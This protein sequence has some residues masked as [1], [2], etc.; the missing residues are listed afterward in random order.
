MGLDLD[1][2][3]DR[4][5]GDAILALTED[6]R[7]DQVI[8]IGSRRK[9]K[10]G[11]VVPHYFAAATAGEFRSWLPELWR[12]ELQVAQASYWI[13]QPMHS[14]VRRELPTASN[15]YKSAWY[16]AT[17][18]RVDG[19]NCL[20]IDLDVGRDGLPTAGDAI[21]IMANAVLEGLIPAPSY[22][23]LSGRGAYAIWRLRLADGGLPPNNELN[24][25]RW[26]AILYRLILITKALELS[27]DEIAKNPARWL[28]LPGTVDTQIDSGRET[29]SGNRVMYLPFLL[30]SPDAKPAVYTF[31]ELESE[32][33]MA[34]PPTLPASVAP[35]ARRVSAPLELRARPDPDGRNGSYVHSARVNEIVALSNSRG[36]MSEPHRHMSLFY[37]YGSLRAQYGC[38]YPGEGIAEQWARARTYELNAS[39][40]PPLAPA[41]V[42]TAIKRR[43]AGAKARWKAS[44]VAA[45]LGVAPSEAEALQLH[46]IAPKV[47]RDD[48]EQRARDGVLDRK[49]AREEKAQAIRRLLLDHS[50]WSDLTVAQFYG[51]IDRQLVAYYRKGLIEEGLLRKPRPPR[52]TQQKLL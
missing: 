19:F 1:Q 24:R 27:P 3:D 18:D 36:G 5:N 8:A 45:A 34:S 38:L 7:D 46:S 44:T 14:S 6:F 4:A 9:T 21:K 23:A 22:M 13:M 16:P 15:E 52:P 2:L 30:D 29:K 17:N 40:N 31:D 47:V 51:G 32:L 48:R 33:G 35:V 41:E 50:G 42:E 12:Y 39:F 20:P 37:F 49:A 11:S 10:A 43:N 26:S 28:K 25:T